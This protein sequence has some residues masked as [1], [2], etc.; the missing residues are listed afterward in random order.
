MKMGIKLRN[1]DNGNIIIENAS[2][3]LEIKPPKLDSHRLKEDIV[4]NHLEIIIFSMLLEM[5]MCG[6]DLIK[7][8]SA[9]YNVLLSQGT[10]YSLLYCLKDENI[11][12]AEFTKCDMRTKRYFITQEGKSIIDKRMYEFVETE[13]C[14]LDSIK[15]RKSIE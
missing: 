14:I 7:E 6:Y 5:P 11:I 2:Q 13:Y 1:W 4:K 3:V 10:V 9:R 12:R 8:I 15:K